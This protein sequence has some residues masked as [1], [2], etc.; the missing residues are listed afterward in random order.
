MKFEL[1]LTYRKFAT[2]VQLPCI[3][4]PISSKVNLSLNYSTVLKNQEINISISQLTELQIQTSNFTNFC[5]NV[6]FS[7]PRSNL[8]SHIAVF[9]C[10]LWPF[11]VFV[12]VTFLKSTGQLFCRMSLS[13]G[14]CVFSWLERQ[15]G[16]ISGARTEPE[17]MLCPN[18]I[19]PLGS[20]MMF[21]CEPQSE[22]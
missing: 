17:I 15:R 4:Y 3:I 1:V 22:G 18:C 6:F 11:L 8:G 2:L 13:L 9:T 20:C 14:L 7:V 10:L 21:M 12:T 16:Y 5:T 19:T